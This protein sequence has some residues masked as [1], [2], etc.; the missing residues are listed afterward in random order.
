MKDRITALLN[1]LIKIFAEKSMNQTASKLNVARRLP[2]GAV[3]TLRVCLTQI[4]VRGLP[5]AR[6]RC[7]NA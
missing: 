5:G 6:G 4:A 1:L 2:A 7:A 3:R